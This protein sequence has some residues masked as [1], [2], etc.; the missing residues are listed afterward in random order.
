MLRIPYVVLRG[1]LHGVRRR[2]S[3]ERGTHV[4]SVAGNLL[5]GGRGAAAQR[6][7]PHS[8]LKWGAGASLSWAA[9]GAQR[10]RKPIL[11]A[12]AVI[13]AIGVGIVGLG[14]S[15]DAGAVTIDRVL[16]E[17]RSGTPL[18]LIRQRGQDGELGEVV[19]VARR[20]DMDAH[21]IP[22]WLFLDDLEL[23]VATLLAV[24]HMLV[25]TVPGC[26]SSSAC[27]TIGS[28][29]VRKGVVLDD[30]LAEAADVAGIPFSQRSMVVVEESPVHDALFSS[31]G[32]ALLVLAMTIAMSAYFLRY[33][34]RSKMVM[35]A[36][37][38][39]GSNSSSGAAKRP[40]NMGMVGGV[41]AVRKEMEHLLDIIQHPW[42]FS[43]SGGRLPSGVLLTGPPG[44]GTCARVV[45]D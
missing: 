24:D 20:C 43:L 17:V 16:E 45:V 18:V 25:R 41:K 9:S 14:T 5:F 38:T 6:G 22:E 42:R 27:R 23:R 39:V 26:V 10:A 2:G 1:A 11:G 3:G 34:E 8:L 7:Q 31:G 12:I 44:T 32:Q 29:R 35:V 15:R 33:M 40:V 4:R 21:P 13:G 36:K 28:L 37:A 19:K 30:L